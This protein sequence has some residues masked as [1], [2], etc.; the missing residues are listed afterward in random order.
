M[1]DKV[2]EKVLKSIIHKCDNLDE[3]IEIS[4]GEIGISYSLFNA[5]AEDLRQKNLITGFYLC[6]SNRD[7]AGVSLSYEGYSYF[8]YK[9]IARNEFYKNLLTSSL[10][11]II[12]SV[13]TTILTTL[14][15]T[16]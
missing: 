16:G 8:E 6:H 4:P 15:L 10:F 13:I 14:I 5:I 3:L 2:S 1:L 12:V 11:N 9:K 7:S